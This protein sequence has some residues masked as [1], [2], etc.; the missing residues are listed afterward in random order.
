MLSTD[1]IKERIDAIKTEMEQNL[2]LID[3]EIDNIQKYH[4]Q[5]TEKI[6]YLL[7]ILLDHMQMGVGESEFKRLNAYYQTFNPE[8]AKIY[9]RVYKEIKED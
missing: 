2:P 3:K 1:D 8:N 9:D 5:S 7:D 4:D 6:E